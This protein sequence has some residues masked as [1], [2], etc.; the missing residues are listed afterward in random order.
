ME[1]IEEGDLA[2]LAELASLAER[3]LFER[4][5]AG[6]G[7]YEGRL[8][9]RAL[10]QGAALHFVDGT[11]GV[12]DFDVWS[13]YTV[14]E[15]GLPFPYRWRG[16]EDY[17][18]SKFGRYPEDPESFIGRR[19]DLLGRSL[20]VGPSADPVAAVREY[21]TAAGSVTARFLASKAVVLVEPVERRGQV[22]WPVDA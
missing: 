1:R 12:K 22:I 6:A 18:P 9:C 19:V 13:F 2:R 16:T 10:C 20:P 14:R 3:G 7:R 21:L 4:N 17:G 5:P 8:L 15:D 11:S